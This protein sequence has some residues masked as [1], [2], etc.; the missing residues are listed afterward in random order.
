MK[1]RILFGVL[2][3]GV[4]SMTA[5]G[6]SA[7]VA[8]PE[9]DM[10]MEE[11]ILQVT[12]VES[13]LVTSA[14]EEEAVL[15]IAMQL[16]E[17]KADVH[18]L[19]LQVNKYL[20]EKQALALQQQLQEQQNFAVTQEGMEI[21]AVAVEDTVFEG[22]PAQEPGAGMVTSGE[23]MPSAGVNS[24]DVFRN[25]TLENAGDEES[26]SLPQ[27]IAARNNDLSDE[28]END[29][30]FLAGFWNGIKGLGTPE[31]VTLAILLVLVAFVAIRKVIFRRRKV[32]I[33]VVNASS[34]K[35]QPQALDQQRKELQ[36]RVAWK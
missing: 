12:L 20:L 31:I 5:V 2:C 28:D 17:I 29:S 27:P 24:E 34:V 14:L 6:T 18:V 23:S 1:K 19:E 21:P 36:E 33:D 13:P 16:E 32:K 25:I 3:V 30:G 4:F 11:G 7:T 10:T 26:N 22:M 15:A 9:S 35:S 8:V